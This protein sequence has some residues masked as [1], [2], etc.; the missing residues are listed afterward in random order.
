MYKL[1]LPVDMRESAAIER[2][3]Q[4]ELERQSRI[5]NAG[6][7]T[8]GV[9]LHA[10]QQQ[11]QERQ[12]QEEQERRRDAAY[13]ADMTRNDKIIML[14][15]KRRENDLRALDECVNKFRQ[16]H[17]QPE[18][19]REFDIY[20]PEG[21]KK[22]KPARVS[23]DDPRCGISSMQKFLGEDLNDV[24][25]KKLQQAQLRAWSEQQAS[26]RALEAAKCARADHL[27]DLKS[28]ELDQRAMQL[29]RD[30]MDCRRNLNLAGKEYNLA[31]A[32]ERCANEDDGKRQA[33]EDNF[34]EISNQVFSDML[35]ENPS[36]ATSAFGSH[37]VIT[38]R[39]K[40]M[41][42]A[43][44]ND[45][46]NTQHEQIE[47]SKRIREEEEHNDK[48][49]ENNRLAQAHTAIIME[50]QQERLRTELNKQ[51]AEENL[52]LATSQKQRKD[53]MDKEMYTNDPTSKY[54][55]QFNTSSR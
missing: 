55:T 27:H 23:D 47:E 9:D 20:D 52:R 36:V 25:R 16:E 5:F 54:F 19:R 13:A 51:Q 37:R 39:W 10:L 14:M 30:E 11:V 46:R 24:E 53:Y 29:E 15:E 35:T 6:V 33:Q 34:T 50:R 8:I 48:Q 17:Q 2:R 41:S 12:N 4:R 18:S 31:L 3:K 45:I 1:D 32:R 40:G 49:W 21:K 38:D 43:E 26:E 22:D 7:R 44:V 42:P 28:L